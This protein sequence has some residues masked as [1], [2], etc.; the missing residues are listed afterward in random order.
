MRW[1]DGALSDPSARACSMKLSLAKLGVGS[2]HSGDYLLQAHKLCKQT[3][4]AKAGE[5]GQSVFSM[6]FSSQTGT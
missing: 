1:L 4:R 5:F 6:G 3:V 2:T